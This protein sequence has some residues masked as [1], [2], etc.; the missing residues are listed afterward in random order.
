MREADAEE[1]RDLSLFRAR[2]WVRGPGIPE[3]YPPHKANIEQAHESLMFAAV[4][5]HQTFVRISKDDYEACPLQRLGAR[6]GSDGGRGDG[7]GGAR[8]S[9]REQS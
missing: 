3:E 7:S 4:R 1:A 5:Y 2:H 9:G 8:V 6:Q